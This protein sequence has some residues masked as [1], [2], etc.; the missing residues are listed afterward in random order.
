M[1]AIVRQR[2]GDPLEIRETPSPAP[3]PREVLVEVR[4]AGVDQGVWHVATGLPY[5]VRAAGFGLRRPRRPI[6][7]LDLAGVVAA[8]GPEVTGLRVGD[9]VFGT[10]D[11]TYAELAVSTEQRLARKPEPVSFAQAATVAGSGVAALQGLRDAGRLRPGQRVLILGAGGGVGSFAVQIARILGAEVTGVCSA[12]KADLVRSLGAAHVIDYA[13]GEPTGRWDLVLDTGGG[14]TL[15]ALRH[16]L[17]PAGT[18]VIVGGEVGGKWLQGTDRQLRA[19]LLNGFTRQRLTG[20][21]SKATAPRLETLAAW[22]ASGALTPV[23]DRTFPFAEAA[24]A[25][26]YLRAGHP[27]GKVALT[28]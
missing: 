5:A 14:R 2:Y 17:T 4:A 23:V 22:M 10:G 9:E 12:A 18:L 16:L 1:R 26:D 7:G 13:T 27:R 15:R 11:G 8:V 25:L 19:G 24:S 6:L 21:L 3:G 20:L 28:L